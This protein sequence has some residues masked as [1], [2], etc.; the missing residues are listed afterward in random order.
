MER[1]VGVVALT[2]AGV[3]FDV[4]VAVYGAEGLF[5]GELGDVSR[6]NEAAV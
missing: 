4:C 2:A 6:D 1:L 3:A 5:I